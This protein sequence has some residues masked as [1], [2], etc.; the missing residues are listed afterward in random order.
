MARGDR[1]VLSATCRLH[2]TPGFTNL[3][4]EPSGAD[5]IRIDPHVDGACELTL[6]RGEVR[7]LVVQLTEWL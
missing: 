5:A 1:L 4:V 3:L 6:D 2:G 7:R